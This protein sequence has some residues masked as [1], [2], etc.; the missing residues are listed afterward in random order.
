MLGFG[1]KQSQA[2]FKDRVTQF[3][4]WYPTVAD[5]F[6]EAIEAGRCED[7]TSEVS[8]ATVFSLPTMAWVFGPGENGGHSFTVSGEG[9]LPKQLLAEYW[10]TRA[11]EISHWTFHASRQPAEEENLKTMAIAIGEHESID[12]ESFLIQTEV[13]DE[14]EKIHI[15]A[16]HPLLEKLPEEHH[17]QILF[18]LLDE[19]LGEFG[20]QTWLGEIKVEAFKPTERTRTIA[21]LP[22][23]IKEVEN[24]HQWEKTPP[25][26][27]YSL[28]EVPEQSD[29]RRGDTLIGTTCIPDIVIEFL[30]N[31]GRLAEDPLPDTGAEFAYVAVDGAIF[32]DGQQS[33]VR[34]NIE[35]ALDESLQS[36]FSG[37]ALGGAFGLSESY[38]DLLLLD[39]DNSRA[40][41]EQTLTALQLDGRSRIESFL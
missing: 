38:I 34:G 6:F 41:V 31:G 5:R 7:L 29:T 23:F 1:K 40:I 21:N 12:T 24:Y 30:E 22:K 10:H 27:A 13:D 3:W 18:I 2:T 35:D 17:Y 19:A 15:V 11:L 4:E 25:L 16:W 32:P 26:R 36:Q 33:D 28:Y 9:Y 39:G 14:A 8:E 37:R 20:T